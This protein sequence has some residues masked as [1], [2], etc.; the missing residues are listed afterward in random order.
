MISPK[1]PTSFIKEKLQ[2]VGDFYMRNRK[3]F[4]VV[5][6]VLLVG[7]M[8]LT[9]STRT[10][11][12]KVVHHG[13]STTYA[14]GS[15]VCGN[16]ICES[17]DAS[18][19]VSNTDCTKI[20]GIAAC[21][22]ISGCTVKDVLI[23]ACSGTTFSC[24]GI[25]NSTTCL[26][27]WCF[28]G[29][30][31]SCSNDDGKW[32][33][34]PETCSTLVQQSQCA[35]VP[36]TAWNCSRTKISSTQSCAWTITKL[37]KES[38]CTTLSGLII[39][40][41]L[42]ALRT[43]KYSE[44]SATCPQDC[45][46]F[47]CG[48]GVKE[49]AETCDNG[50]NNSD[51]MPWACKK[52]CDGY[53]NA[54]CN[55]TYFPMMC[56]QLVVPDWA[57]KCSNYYSMMNNQCAY[58]S[59]NNI[60]TEWSSC[61]VVVAAVCGNGSKEWSE[62]CDD[63][64]NN[65]VPGKCNATCD[66]ITPA[67]VVCGNWIVEWDEACD[68]GEKNSYYNWC[69]PSCTNITPLCSGDKV[70][71][72][73][74]LDLTD[75]KN[76]CWNYYDRGYQCQHDKNEAVDCTIRGLCSENTCGDWKVA[77]TETCDDGA[78]NG[79]PGKCNTTCDGYV[80]ATCSW[81]IVPSNKTCIELPL[82]NPDKDCSKYYSI[83]NAQCKYNTELPGTCIEGNSCVVPTSVCW[84]GEVEWTEICDD[85]NTTNGDGCSSTCELQE[86]TIPYT[87]W[88]EVT[89][90][91]WDGVKYDSAKK[92]FYVPAGVSVFTFT[93]SGIALWYGEGKFVF[94][95]PYT[96]TWSITNV[97]NSDSIGRGSD[98]G[99][100]FMNYS[101][102]INYPLTAFTF[103]DSRINMQATWTGWIWDFSVKWTA[104]IWTSIWSLGK[105]NCNDLSLADP[106]NECKS[107]YN[108]V[109]E[110][111]C[112][113]A[114]LKWGGWYICR[115][116]R[117]NTCWVEP[118]TA[119]WDGKLEKSEECDDGNIKDNDGCSSTCKVEAMT[120]GDSIIGQ[121]EMC[122]NGI[123]NGKPGQCNAT[124]DG[125][126]ANNG[127][128]GDGVC[129][130]YCTIDS[131]ITCN[132]LNK[133]K[134][135]KNLCS[136][137]GCFLQTKNIYDCA[138]TVSCEK[139]TKSTMYNDQYMVWKYC[140]LAG[141][142]YDN[143]SWLCS[144]PSKAPSCSKLPAAEY[145]KMLSPMWCSLTT[146]GVSTTCVGNTA[147]RADKLD[148]N[149]CTTINGKRNTE[150]ENSC[151]SDCKATCTTTETESC[152]SL[153]VAECTNY[154]AQNTN[155]MVSKDVCTDGSA[156]N[157]CGNNVCDNKETY[158]TC[159]SDCN[160]TDWP[161][162]S[163]TPNL[164]KDWSLVT[165]PVVAK[166]KFWDGC[167]ILNN[168]ASTSYT[169]NYN[170]YFI[171]K[172]SCPWLDGKVLDIWAKV[173]RLQNNAKEMTNLA[174]ISTTSWSTLYCENKNNLIGEVAANNTTMIE[175]A[176]KAIYEQSLTSSSSTLKSEFS[177]KVTVSGN[178]SFVNGSN[179]LT[180]IELTKDLLG[181]ATKATLTIPAN[182]TVK[183]ENSKGQKSDFSG[184]FLAPTLA[185]DTI[186]DKLS[187]QIKN[188][189]NNDVAVV[190]KVGDEENTK[191]TV[192][193]T[194]DEAEEFIISLQLTWYQEWD[195][196]EILSSQDGEVWTSYGF[197]TVNDKGE[198][199]FAVPHLTYYGIAS[200]GETTSEGGDTTTPTSSNG[201]GGGAW[202]PINQ[203]TADRDCKNNYLTTLCGP[204][205]EAEKVAEIKVKQNAVVCY[206]YSPELNG[207]YSFAYANAI[208]TIADCEKANLN[209]DLLRSHMAKM[210]SNFA[211]NTLGLK[212]N[213][214]AVCEFTDM[215]SETTEMKFYAKLAC[216]LGLMWLDTDG[217]A[218]TIFT[219]N[220]VV[221]RAQFGTV[222]SR[223]LRG[224]K[225][226][227]GEIY[228]QKHLQALQDAEIMTKIDEPSNKE[229]RGRT[230]L[231]M[232]RITNKVSPAENGGKT[233]W[234]LI[235][236]FFTK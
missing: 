28:R 20:T 156:C 194:G 41:G 211:I 77:T 109:T 56:N 144:T 97:S 164:P 116:D 161:S 75:P 13:V 23:Y 183:S 101:G 88:G 219:P 227:G 125:W 155:C 4:A 189:K 128:C 171:F 216:Q 213:T 119:C 208:T 84:N 31:N 17:S 141:C 215:D 86:Q 124:C 115:E 178:I 48:N 33:I 182:S 218:N 29:S 113:S 65:G 133:N 173:Y 137:L 15:G 19:A 38:D 71:Y 117:N 68:D 96:T 39:S 147:L 192:V 5:K 36:A 138:G 188:E 131:N 132:S 114:L 229:M 184:L 217:K 235:Q 135:T 151:P 112:T 98:Y 85:K 203:C 142:S 57:K 202:A 27:V 223:L 187:T 191:L 179:T 53:I 175:M 232:Q 209:G 170:G 130:T 168:N 104:C 51:V 100:F 76:E 44:D 148:S 82:A 205:S 11:S 105:N 134:S 214:G 152:S 198:V 47:V 122:D 90:T 24:T 180:K 197:T 34:A 153:S 99:V 207:A 63:G 40:F 154:F 185:S 25:S 87:T 69:S 230:M 201:G 195:E 60:C 45:S 146:D 78:N 167:K 72:C 64:A 10:P 66:W 79:E 18:C 140:N 165:W 111:Q 30:N 80:T 92:W 50:G 58:D 16:A 163:Y 93:D 157:S 228:Y 212:P 177:D 162:V 52:T 46:A 236:E 22:A 73:S 233:L 226:N 225:N 55:G 70:S 139:I 83:N 126:L 160:V 159:P 74:Q 95:I 176:K 12:G 193:D 91:F 3:L 120:C 118:A 102:T 103:T 8:T 143:K 110:Q 231:M 61:T 224:N 210:M 21:A 67:S 145:C 169:F 129:G 127:S 174:A 172:V 14:W 59:K 166:V 9:F 81:I 26:Q 43:P 190:L 108:S 204:C 106:V 123:N 181:T 206:S 42:T 199:N 32:K 94:M 49:W 89:I 149:Q 158:S 107:Y 222:L 62:T 221:T 7:V 196:V 37:T 150:D 54:T 186:V 200:E 2:A 1:K 121:G 136:T 234:E 220:Q 35:A 6:L